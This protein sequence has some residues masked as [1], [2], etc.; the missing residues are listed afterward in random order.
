M[1]S[2]SS[3]KR[4]NGGEE[5][6]LNILV[7]VLKNRCA[8]LSLAGL[9]LFTRCCVLLLLCVIKC[10]ECVRILADN[11]RLLS[12]S[13]LKR[14]TRKSFNDDD[15]MMITMISLQRVCFIIFEA[16][17]LSR[18]ETLFLSLSFLFVMMMLKADSPRRC[19]RRF[20]YDYSRYYYSR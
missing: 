13:A 14:T 10:V 1:E 9:S 17:V 19:V 2:S 8:M 5:A 12:S 6:D 16:T 3:R 15:V 20:Y 18:P 11:S 7:V 4:A